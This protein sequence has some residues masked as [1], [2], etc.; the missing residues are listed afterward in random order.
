MP[1]RH[2]RLGCESYGLGFKVEGLGFRLVRTWDSICSDLFMG[3]SQWARIKG[4]R[5]ESYSLS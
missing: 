2:R 5:K 1:A 3:D 4:Q